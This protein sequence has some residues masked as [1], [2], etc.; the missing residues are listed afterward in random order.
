MAMEIYARHPETGEK[1]FRLLCKD[2]SVA[3]GILRILKTKF[4]TSKKMETDPY[5]QRYLP[6]A[7]LAGA[8]QNFF[9][10]PSLLC[11]Q[12]LADNLEFAD[13]REFLGF[14]LDGVD[15]ADDGQNE[16]DDV[17]NPGEGAPAHPA[18]N[19]ADH[20][21]NQQDKSLIDME[22]GEFRFLGDEE[23]NQDENAQVGEHGHPF[24]G[25]G[26]FRGEFRSAV[27]GGSRSRD[28]RCGGVRCGGLDNRSFIG[29]CVADRL[30]PKRSPCAGNGTIIEPFLKILK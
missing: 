14:A 25:A 5:C 29:G 27:Q 12:Y 21:A 24:V 10:G 19:G 18:E 2:E 28:V 26:V 30:F 13:D 15:D 20:A 1:C 8:G 17:Q 4:P 3:N 6:A 22:A 7:L 11:G 23:G 9:A 16:D